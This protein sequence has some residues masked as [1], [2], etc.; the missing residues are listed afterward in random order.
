M[1]TLLGCILIGKYT[2]ASRLALSSVPPVAVLVRS[3]CSVRRVTSSRHQVEGFRRTPR[4]VLGH[5]DCTHGGTRS[6]DHQLLWVLSR[7][8]KGWTSTT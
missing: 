2:S 8:K 4:Q 6:T 1:I 5:M 7:D 3:R